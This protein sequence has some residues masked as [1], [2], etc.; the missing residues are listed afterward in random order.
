MLIDS[1]QSTR[2]ERRQPDSQVFGLSNWKTGV[3]LAETGKPTEGASG[4]WGRSGVQS[5]TWEMQHVRCLLEVR[6]EVSSRQS[7]PSGAEMPT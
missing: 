4:G 5:G 2:R 1:K 3:A 7:G 6:E